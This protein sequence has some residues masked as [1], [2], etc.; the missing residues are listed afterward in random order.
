MLQRFLDVL[1][2]LWW[3][4]PLGPNERG[5]GCLGERLEGPSSP[6]VALGR[7]PQLRVLGRSRKPPHSA[8]ACGVRTAPTDPPPLSGSLRPTGAAVPVTS[9]ALIIWTHCTL[10]PQTHRSSVGPGA[11]T[12]RR[13][14]FLVSSARF[15]LA[16]AMGILRAAVRRL[17]RPVW[18]A[19]EARSSDTQ[20]FRAELDALDLQYAAFH[21]AAWLSEASFLSPGLRFAV[22]PGAWPPRCGCPRARFARAAGD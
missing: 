4:R 17:G 18:C 11:S 8:I 21:F 14:A 3:A 2:C 16:A 7:G 6:G 9:P 22:P 1:R 12:Q 13:P 15:G 19:H 5:R 20:L 10:F